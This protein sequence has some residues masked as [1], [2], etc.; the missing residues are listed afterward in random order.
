MSQQ[1]PFCK[2]PECDRCLNH[3]HTADLVCAVH[4]DGVQERSERCADFE[5]DPNCS[6][7]EGWEPEEASFYGNEL[8]ISPLQRWNRAQK[9]ELLMWHPLFTGL[10]PQCCTQFFDCS[11]RVHWDCPTTGLSLTRS[12]FGYVKDPLNPVFRSTDLKPLSQLA[13]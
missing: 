4:P 12:Q 3:P 7:G 11:A 10:C 8:I 6:R 13:P 9:L 5:R 2:R 1:T